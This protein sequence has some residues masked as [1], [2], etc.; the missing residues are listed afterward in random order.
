MHQQIKASP[1]STAENIQRVVN[2]LSGQGINIEAIAPDHDP[3]H[4]RVV[5][6]HGDVEAALEILTA[7]GL[8]P[9][10]KSAVQVTMPNEPTALQ[11]AMASLARRGFTIES[12]LT[13]AATQGQGGTATISFG[14]ARSGIPGWDETT[15]GELGNDVATDAGA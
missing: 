10:L 1:N 11:K 8:V 6:A 12:M 14:I 5:V 13:V 2:A 4:V 7:E 15:A 9:Q 3:P